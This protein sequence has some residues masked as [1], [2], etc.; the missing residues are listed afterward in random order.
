M[1]ASAEIEDN[2]VQWNAGN[3]VDCADNCSVSGNTVSSNSEDGI[4]VYGG[5]GIVADNRVFGNTLTGIQVSGASAG[6]PN[7]ILRNASNG[8][9]GGNYSIGA[10]NDPGPQSAAGGASSPST[11]YS[12]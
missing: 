3:G 5:V 9:A 8:N 10:N 2:G 4:S 6:F 11:N 12:Q 7:V 1:G